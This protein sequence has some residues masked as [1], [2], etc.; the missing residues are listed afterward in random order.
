MILYIPILNALNTGNTIRT[1]IPCNDYY[2]CHDIVI[3]TSIYGRLKLFL[4]ATRN[5]SSFITSNELD[6]GAATAEEPQERQQPEED[7][8][9][10]SEESGSEEDNENN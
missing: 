4:N 6:L 9:Q 2:T 7:Q 5:N 8:P 1:L 10:P 3:S